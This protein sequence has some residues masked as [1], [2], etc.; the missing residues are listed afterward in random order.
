MSKRICS[1]FL[2]L[3]RVSYCRRQEG[4]IN[5]YT[6]A[7]EGASLYDVLNLYNRKHQFI[8]D[9]LIRSMNDIED[10]EDY[11]KKTED[12]QLG[13]MVEIVK[14]YGN[15]IPGLIRKIKEMHVGNDEK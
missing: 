8:R 6:Y 7:D 11:I 4:N 13:M 15:E 10:L 3:F 9:L 1:E 12:L 2:K 14:E 5:S